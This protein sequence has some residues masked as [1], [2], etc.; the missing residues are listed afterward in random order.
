MTRDQ[1]ALALQQ[2]QRQGGPGRPLGSPFTPAPTLQ[3]PPP[4]AGTPNAPIAAA[5]PQYGFETGFKAGAGPQAATD[6]KAEMMKKFMQLMATGGSG[7][8]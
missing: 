3:G 2:Q 8:P 1:I 6:D 7:A 5:I 4:V